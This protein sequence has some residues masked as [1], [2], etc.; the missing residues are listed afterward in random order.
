MF[1]LFN[2]KYMY[3]NWVF[4]FQLAEAGFYSCA[5]ANEPDAVQCFMCFKELDGWEP[6]DDPW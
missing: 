5:T 1:N 3:I 2:E 4:F 6:D